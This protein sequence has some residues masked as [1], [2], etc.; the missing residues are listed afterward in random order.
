MDRTC[1]AEM[2]TTTPPGAVAGRKV[3]EVVAGADALALEAGLVAAALVA[4]ALA[5]APPTARSAAVMADVHPFTAPTP[6][7]APQVG[8]DSLRR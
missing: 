3:A 2:V 5:E 8:V 7:V 1:G 4:A 6:D